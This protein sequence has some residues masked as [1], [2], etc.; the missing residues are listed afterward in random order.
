MTS[1][2]AILDAFSRALDRL[3]AALA[4]P[5]SEWTRDAA[6]QRF[7]F[8]FELA[9]KATARRVRAEGLEASSPRRAIRKAVQLGLIAD[10]AG[11]LEML[12]DRNLTSHT[13]N[14]AV[15]EEI[16]ARLGAHARSLSDL[17]A[18]LRE[19]P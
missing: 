5:K 11:W 19:S 18:A 17:L 7:E 4:Q 14:E 1:D 10:D 2:I 15:A 9:W 8:T 13:Y 3:Q 6:I 16:Y 12:N